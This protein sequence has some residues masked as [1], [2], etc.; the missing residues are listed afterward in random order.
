MPLLNDLHPPLRYF[1]PALHFGDTG[2]IYQSRARR[3]SDTALLGSH[4]QALDRILCLLFGTDWSE[5]HKLSIRSD[6][7]LSRDYFLVCTDGRPAILIVKSKFG[8]SASYC[9]Y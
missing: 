1:L 8:A 7:L 6:I 3:L 5:F 4:Y 9:P 2:C